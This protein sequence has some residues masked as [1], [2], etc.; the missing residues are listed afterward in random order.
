MVKDQQRDLELEFQSRLKE[1][2]EQ[3]QMS[4]VIDGNGNEKHFFSLFIEM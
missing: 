4:V 3:I 1:I 2:Q